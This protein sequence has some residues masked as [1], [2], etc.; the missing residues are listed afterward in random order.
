LTHPRTNLRRKGECEETAKQY[1]TR[2]TQSENA[3]EHIRSIAAVH[4][5]PVNKR[6]ETVDE[7]TEDAE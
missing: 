4:N 7:C 1:Y 5:T 3:Q 6:A 2:G